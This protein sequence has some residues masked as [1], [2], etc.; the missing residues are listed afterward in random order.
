MNRTLVN[1]LQYAIAAAGGLFLL[2]FSLHKI[3]FAEL[4]QTLR[5][6]NYLVVLP[7]AL[8]SLLVYWLR[9]HR[10]RLLFETLE[11]RPAKS[12][13]FALL[14]VCYLVNF[15][16]PRLGEI[17]RCLLLKKSD[18]AP[19]NVSLS[20]IVFE[21]SIDGL[22]LFLLLGVALAT[23][24]GNTGDVFNK[25]DPG[26]LKLGTKIF[27]LA[28][29]L[30]IFFISLYLVRRFN[31]RI[32]E[33]MRGF[34]ESM[35]RLLKMKHGWLFILETIGIWICYYLMTYLW[36]FT[37]DDSAGLN[38]FQA[39]QVMVVGTFARS[40]P[41]QAGGAGAYHFGVSQALQFMGVSMLTGN[42]LAIIIHGFQTV[43][44][45]ILGGGS[46]FWF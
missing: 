35:L 6:G 1:L 36:F 7:V 32:T 37:F 10:W 23:A 25:Y 27:L 2:Y 17:L 14:A 13:L 29:A 19:L 31:N 28:A 33:W 43:L 26:D 38:L 4:A 15:V 21:R 18:K 42:A 3:D 22:C 24:A 45:L 34:L 40:L 5:N 30:L 12:H 16:V 8:I 9:I 44:T 41:I 39:F 20:T 11:M 46:Y